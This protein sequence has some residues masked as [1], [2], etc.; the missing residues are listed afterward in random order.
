MSADNSS[1]EDSLTVPVPACPED[2]D[3]ASQEMNAWRA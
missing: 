1:I 3:D 2:A